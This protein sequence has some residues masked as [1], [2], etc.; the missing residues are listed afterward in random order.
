MTDDDD[1]FLGEIF[2]VNEVTKNIK[3]GRDFVEFLGMLEKEILEDDEVDKRLQHQFVN[4]S[5]R[6]LTY[7]TKFPDHDLDI[8]M[9]DHPDW[10]WL[11]RLFFLGAFEN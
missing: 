4:I 11:A 7:A 8:E 9:P 1:R 3:S 6:K 5:R 10:N 2:E